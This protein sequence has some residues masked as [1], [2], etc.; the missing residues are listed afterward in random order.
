[1]LDASEAANDYS[2]VFRL[3]YGGFTALFLGDVS[4]TVEDALVERYGRELDVDLLKVAHH[5]SATSTGAVLL[6]QTTPGVALV[7]V[8]RRNRYRHPHPAVIDRLEL[9][10]AHVLR[11]DLQG[12]V[13]LRVTPDGR[14]SA[15]TGQ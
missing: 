11:T 8:G 3:R 5:G 1:L 2:A 7:P 10:G 4:T 12:T 14:M 15:R 13:S 6:T 9:A